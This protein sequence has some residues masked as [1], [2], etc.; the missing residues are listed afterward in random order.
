MGFA[1]YGELI[2]AVRKCEMLNGTERKRKE[3][4]ERKCRRGKSEL[5]RKREIAGSGKAETME[6]KGCLE[7]VEKRVRIE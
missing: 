7:E 1:E 6:D 3:G 2:T 4:G 5:E